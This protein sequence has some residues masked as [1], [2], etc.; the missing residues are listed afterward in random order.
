MRLTRSSAATSYTG[1]QAAPG[2]ASVDAAISQ[3]ARDTLAALFPSQMPTFDTYLAEDLAVIRNSRQKAN[4]IDLGQRTAAAIL[5]MRLNDGSQIPEPRVGVDYF[6]S[7]LPGH[8]RQDPISLIPL[9]LGTRWGECIP[10]VVN[11]TIQFRAP[12]PPALTSSIYTAAYNEVKN[13]G[14]DGLNTPTQRTEEQ[15]FIGAF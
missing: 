5:A 4:G 7:D 15:S 6:P 10:F 3:A 13:L 11:S 14:G 8:W 9:A 12:P 2:A 1:T